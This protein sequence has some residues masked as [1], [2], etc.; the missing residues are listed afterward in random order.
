[1]ALLMIKV[2]DH[3]GTEG[4]ERKRCEGGKKKVCAR[5][6]QWRLLL[7]QLPYR[8]IVLVISTLWHRLMP[9]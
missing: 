1:M 2:A 4:Y 7:H 9:G 8:G 6:L 3:F 5:Q